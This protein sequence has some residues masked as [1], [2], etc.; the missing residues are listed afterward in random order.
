MKTTTIKYED[1]FKGEL[2]LVN[3]AYSYQTPS[4]TSLIP[5]NDERKGIFL[6]R[7]AAALL[8]NVIVQVGG[9]RQIA[10]VSGWRSDSEQE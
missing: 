3:Q 1:I 9:W 6:D 2:I 8:S 7:K 4:T 5:I 10:A